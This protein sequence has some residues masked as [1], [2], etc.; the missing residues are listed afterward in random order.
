MFAKFF[1]RTAIL[2][3]L[4]LVATFL[5][6]PAASPGAKDEKEEVAAAG[7]KW[8]AIFVDDNPDSI[9]TMYDDQAVFWGTLSPTLF[10][11]K[12]ALRDYFQMAFKALP[13]HKVT[14]GNQHIRV[15]K[16]IAIH[17][18]DYTFWYVKDGETKSLPA[19][20]SFVYQ[21]RDGNW[22]IVDHH[23]SAMPAPPK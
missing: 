22:L 6:E 15:Y 10:V 1:K 16:D 17:S 20:Y 21:K 18:G 2:N 19:R 12:Q 13:G 5:V 8:T 4:P 14:F 11:G 9:L 3:R 7:A 23:S